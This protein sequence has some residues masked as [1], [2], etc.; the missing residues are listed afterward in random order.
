MFPCPAFC[1]S[2]PAGDKVLPHTDIALFCIKH[3][4]PSKYQGLSG[5]RQ[6]G[7]LR[8]AAELKAHGIPLW[9]RYVLIPGYTDDPKDIDMLVDF[10]QQQPTLQG[11]ELLPYHRLGVNKWHELG[12]RYPLEGVSVPTLEQTL[13]V[14]DRL[15]GSGLN[16]TC[17]AKRQHADAVAAAARQK[18]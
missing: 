15:E 3:L 1:R 2:C 14:V 10:A 6:L 5:L 11:V 16:V 18:H 4:D 13:R 9:L 12:L 17:D 8:F 7:A